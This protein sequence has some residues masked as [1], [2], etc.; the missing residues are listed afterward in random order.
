M[1]LP[2]KYTFKKNKKNQSYGKNVRTF[3]KV[4]TD[5]VKKLCIQ[6]WVFLVQTW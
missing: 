2:K 3:L 1:K 6:N 4:T 5:I